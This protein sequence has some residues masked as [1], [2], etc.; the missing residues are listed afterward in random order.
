[1]SVLSQNEQQRYHRHLLLDEIGEAGQIK[2]KQAKVLVVGAGGLGCPVIQ[3]LCTTGVGLITI[4]DDDVVDMSNLQRQVFYGVNDLGKHK[5]II[6]T[7]LMRQRNSSIQVEQVVARIT[8]KNARKWVKEHDVIMD[9]TDNLQARYVLSDACVLE[10]KPLVHSSVYK[11]Q[12]QLSVFNYENGPSYRCLFPKPSTENLVDM[13]TLGIYS[14]LP[15][16]M[17]LMQANET[18]KIIVGMGQVLSGKM[19]IYDSLN[20]GLNYIKIARDPKSFD[21]AELS[22][23][24]ENHE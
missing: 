3:Y 16:I 18:L 14:V 19:L 23:L 10:G 1:M 11:T 2:I 20:Q 17:G 15:G 24:F 8:Y 6:A 7:S 22:L 12:G 9:C 4:V 21:L 13:P 5:A